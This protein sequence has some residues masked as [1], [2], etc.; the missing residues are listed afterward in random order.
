MRRGVQDLEAFGSTARI[1]LLLIIFA[2]Q[3]VADV[4]QQA[5][6]VSSGV[7]VSSSDR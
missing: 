2:N 1:E 4:D 6:M 5:L 3:F 7:H